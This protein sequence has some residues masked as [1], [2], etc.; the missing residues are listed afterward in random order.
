M[1]TEYSNIRRQLSKVLTFVLV[2]VQVVGNTVPTFAEVV[3]RNEEYLASAS[4]AIKDSKITAVTKEQ[5][6]VE[7]A[8]SSDMSRYDAGDMLCLDV[9][10]KN[11]TANRIT[12]SVLKFSGKGISKDTSYFEVD[13]DIVQFRDLSGLEGGA[14]MLLLMN[15]YQKKVS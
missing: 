8:V 14:K 4:N 7:I 10:V 5:Q 1:R 9:Y 6:D 12:D 11:N 3:N 2:F 13:S 15:T